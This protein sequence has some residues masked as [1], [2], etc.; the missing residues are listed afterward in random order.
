MEWFSSRISR[1]TQTNMRSPQPKHALFFLPPSQ[2]VGK[3]DP[4]IWVKKPTP[5][6]WEAP[7]IKKEAWSH[8]KRNHWIEPLAAR[9]VEYPT[10]WATLCSPNIA[11]SITYVECFWIW[12]DYWTSLKS[13]PTIRSLVRTMTLGWGSNYKI[14]K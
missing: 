7:Y 4:T 1:I 14:N 9:E 6:A 10:N 13:G 3:W 12:I 2:E 5:V 8:K 11:L